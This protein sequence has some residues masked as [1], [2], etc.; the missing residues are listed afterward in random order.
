MQIAL[1]LVFMN[2]LNTA[3]NPAAIT[4]FIATGI[5]VIRNDRSLTSL[6]LAFLCGCLAIHL[7]LSLVDYAAIHPFLSFLMAR[8][9]SL[10]PGLFW[11]LAFSWFTES[12]RIPSYAFYVVIAYVLVRA[13][14]VGLLFTGVMQNNLIFYTGFI[15]IPQIITVLITVHAIYL[16]LNGYGNDL[17]ST[18]RKTRIAFV[19]AVSLFIILTRIK[20]WIVY[21]QVVVSGQV[22]SVATPW[23]D[24]TITLFA[25]ILSFMLFLGLLTLRSPVN[26][27]WFAAT[28]TKTGKSLSEDD[29]QL[30]VL[31]QQ[32]IQVDKRFL[33]PNLTIKVF[34]QELGTHPQKLRTLLSTELKFEHFNQFL[35]YYRIQEAAIR[36]K[37]SDLNISSIAFDVGFSSLSTFN[38]A[39][40]AIHDTPPSAYRASQAH[41][42]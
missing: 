18:R 25:L 15:A 4:L 11:L 8:L 5:A 32:R 3:L 6:L 41:D 10:V 28:K 9:S 17:I 38:T 39:F 33:E 7:S 26:T 22:E 14:G 37:N 35:N 12:R 19:C 31:I 24:S 36:L 29:K 40:K 30:L 21:N 16:A 27:L 13:T 23:L 34:A 20:T 42:H 1:S 2:L